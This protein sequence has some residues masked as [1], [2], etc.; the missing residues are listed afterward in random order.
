MEKCLNGY[1]GQPFFLWYI[2]LQHVCKF[3]ELTCKNWICGEDLESQVT[4]GALGCMI[5]KEFVLIWIPDYPPPP[6]L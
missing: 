1:H 3:A 6:I 5:D 2:S 4:S